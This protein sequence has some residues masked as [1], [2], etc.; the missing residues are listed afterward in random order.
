MSERTPQD[1]AI[2][3]AEYMAQS[4]EHLIAAVND[5]GLAEQE[6]DEG[7]ANASDVDAARDTLTEMLGDMRN[8]IYEFRK[9]RD[10]A[11]VQAAQ[12]EAVGLIRAM[13]HNAMDRM[14]RA[15]NLLT[16]GNP[17][18]ECNWGMLDTSDLRKA[19]ASAPT[20]EPI[21]A[22]TAEPVATW[23][24][25]DYEAEKQ[26][27]AQLA[28]LEPGTDLYAT[29]QSA[30]TPEPSDAERLDAARWRA[31]IGLDYALR[32]EW[33]TNLSL[34][35][36]LTKWVDNSIAAMTETKGGK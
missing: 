7:S 9:R 25:T 31:F 17:R 16:D 23:M 3:H 15:R 27:F 1:F 22:P 12:P 36:I 14:D 33:A 5:L 2:E 18:P 30:A 34:A 8:S 11:A 21:S 35:P 4:A 24:G 13:L 10:R 26:C 19:L 32:A 29:P 20:P 28:H 6:H